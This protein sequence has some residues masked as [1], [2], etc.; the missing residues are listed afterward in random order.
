[1]SNNT[2]PSTKENSNSNSFISS[3]EPN[4]KTEIEP[5]GVEQFPNKTQPISTPL[6]LK[7]KFMQQYSS[8]S[9]E[10]ALS[11]VTRKVLE[12]HG[13]KPKKL[14]LSHKFDESF[15]PFEE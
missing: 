9:E 2:K 10:I 8:P 6:M 7:R 4:Q 14:D 11:P 12:K 3:E 5:K 1:M 13:V 15:I